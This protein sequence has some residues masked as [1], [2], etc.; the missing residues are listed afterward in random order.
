[1]PAIARVVYGIPTAGANGRARPDPRETVMRES[2]DTIIVVGLGGTGS[3]A[4]P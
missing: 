1:M 4:A 3:T 2:Y